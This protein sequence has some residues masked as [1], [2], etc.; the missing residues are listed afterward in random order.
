MAQSVSSQPRFSGLVPVRGWAYLTSTHSVFS[1]QAA[2]QSS[3]EVVVMAA[4]SLPPKSTPHMI[5]YRAFL[6]EVY[7]TRLLAL[8]SQLSDALEGVV[9]V[10]GVVAVESVVAAVVLLE[11]GAY[12]QR[13]RR[14]RC[15]QPASDPS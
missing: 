11:P 14:H 1:S 13:P 9:V 10:E 7:F 3:N 15:G 5:W 8:P 4:M 12:A 2:I 6:A